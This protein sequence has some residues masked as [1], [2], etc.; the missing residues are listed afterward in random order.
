MI[1][2]ASMRLLGG[3]III[4][5]SLELGLIFHEMKNKY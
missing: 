1:K 2:I 3:H 4:C 5:T